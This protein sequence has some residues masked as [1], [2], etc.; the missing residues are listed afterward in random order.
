MRPL[1]WRARG[2][3]PGSRSY[4]KSSCFQDGPKKAQDV[5]EQPKIASWESS[6]AFR[7]CSGRP[8]NPNNYTSYYYYHHYYHYQPVTAD[9]HV[10]LAGLL[11]STPSGTCDLRHKGLRPSLTTSLREDDTEALGLHSRCPCSKMY[12]CMIYLTDHNDTHFWKTSATAGAS[13]LC[14]TFPVPI[15]GPIRLSSLVLLLPNGGV[16]ISYFKIQAKTLVLNTKQIN[17]H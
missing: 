4:F 9:T 10:T 13:R 8:W 12:V 16:P 5:P 1:S 17:R 6:W 7:R 2:T 3:V 11:A 14:S 15:P